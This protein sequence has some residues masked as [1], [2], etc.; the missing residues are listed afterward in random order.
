VSSLAVSLERWAMNSKP[1]PDSVR[2][3]GQRLK[4]EKRIYKL[5]KSITN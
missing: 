1:K 4:R 5:R 3:T 2:S